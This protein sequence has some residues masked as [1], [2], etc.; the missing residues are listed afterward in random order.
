MNR[1]LP[2]V[3]LASAAMLSLLAGCAPQPEIAPTS[4]PTPTAA[5]DPSPS[6]EPV[7]TEPTEEPAPEDP[8]CETLLAPST[9]AMFDEHGWTYREQEFRFGEDVVDGGFQCVWGDYSVAS[10]HVQVFGWTPLDASA[11]AA[12]QQSAPLN[13][14]ERQ[15]LIELRRK[16]RQV[17]QERDI[18]A[19]ATAWFA[20]K[21]EQMPKAF[22]R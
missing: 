17:Q 12:V 4:T 18:L 10:D 16:L 20:G 13:A 5:A 1:R 19:K 21:S 7:A 11:S 15:E 6:P 9:L 2:A 8:T 3:S 14:A 22:T